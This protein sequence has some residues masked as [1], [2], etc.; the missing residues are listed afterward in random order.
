M[1]RPRLGSL[2]R[3]RPVASRRGCW[4]W[5]LLQRSRQWR[6]Q[7]SSQLRHR[8]KIIN[9]MAFRMKSQAT[10]QGCL[11]TSLL[12][13]SI[14]PEHLRRCRCHLSEQARACRALFSRHMRLLSRRGSCRGRA[15]R[16]RLGWGD[17]G[18]RRRDCRPSGG[19]AG[20]C[21]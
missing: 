16:R 6:G 18:S 7:W 13:L 19:A 3:C 14:R 21:H 9:H 20:W 11:V 4:S 1:L 5:N 17:V 15:S 10:V 12:G 2:R 8:C